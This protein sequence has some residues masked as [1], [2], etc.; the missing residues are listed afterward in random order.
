[1]QARARM[2][3]SRKGQT[4]E[5][6]AVVRIVKPRIGM[7]VEFIDVE[8]TSQETLSRWIGQLRQK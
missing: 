7:G 1:L 2:T 6:L 5:G 4:V 8:S 3:L